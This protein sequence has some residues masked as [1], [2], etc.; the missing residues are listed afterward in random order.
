MS[1][2][3]SALEIFGDSF[4]IN[5]IRDIARM[6]ALQGVVNSKEPNHMAPTGFSTVRY[7]SV[8]SHYSPSVSRRTS[9]SSFDSMATMPLSTGFASNRRSTPD[10]FNAFGSTYSFGGQNYAEIQGDSAY[11]YRGAFMF[12]MV[13]TELFIA[14]GRW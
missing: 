9:I 8:G 12:G 11:A 14:N 6:S 10:N 13:I 2:I 4:R 3:K 1:E 7:G 5:S